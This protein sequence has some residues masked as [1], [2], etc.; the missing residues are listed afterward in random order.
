MFIFRYNGQ[1]LQMF[2]FASI[3]ASSMFQNYEFL[4]S[5]NEWYNKVNKC[6][7][8]EARLLK[9]NPSSTTYQLCDLRKVP[10]LLCTLVSS[11][12]YPNLH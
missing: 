7:D 4:S 10:L 6:M 8:S 2:F 9:F 5:A 11:S 3:A 1:L 12:E